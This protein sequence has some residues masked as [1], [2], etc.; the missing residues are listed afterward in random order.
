MVTNLAT[1]I[2]PGL[3]GA[4][5]VRLNS[6]YSPIDVPLVSHHLT[7][8]FV[9]RRIV[10]C[11]QLAIDN[12]KCRVSRQARLAQPH[13]TK[14]ARPATN[15]PL[16]VHGGSTLPPPLIARTI[17]TPASRVDRTQRPAAHT[18]LVLLHVASRS[19]NP[20]PRPGPTSF[21]RMPWPSIGSPDSVPQLAKADLPRR[22]SH[23]RQSSCGLDR[24]PDRDHQVH[25]GIRVLELRQ[26]PRGDSPS[27]RTTIF[28]PWL[29]RTFKMSWAVGK[30]IANRIVGSQQR[31][32]G[33]GSSHHRKLSSIGKFCIV[34]V[35][36]ELLPVA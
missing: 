1:S 27:P 18:Q 24:T 22:S 30:H 8:Q 17:R 4:A 6:W 11:Q 20:D 25:L 31:L 23:R 35:D 34:G 3:P 32:V 21:R 28:T 13:R 36:I 14:P 10:L 7:H 15:R 5:S 2:F 33:S 12:G 19:P 29:I 9:E 16:T 26:I